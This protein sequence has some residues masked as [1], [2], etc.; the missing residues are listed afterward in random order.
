MESAVFGGSGGESCAD[1]RDLHLAQRLAAFGAGNF[2][3]EV[4]GVGCNCQEEATDVGLQDV[5][6]GEWQEQ[7]PLVPV[8]SRGGGWRL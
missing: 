8:S 2:A 1:D 3:G 7:F 4:G 5:A 6:N